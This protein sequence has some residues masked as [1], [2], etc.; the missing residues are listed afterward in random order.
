MNDKVEHELL[1]ALRWRYAVKKFDSH[2]RIPDDTWEII[3]QSLVLTP[4]SYGLQPWRFVVVVDDEV[5]ANLKAVSWNQPQPAE[6]SHLVV[7]AARRNV[8]ADYVDQHM[9][10]LCRTRELPSGAMEGYRRVLV[11]TVE[12]LTPEQ[13]LNWNSRQVYIALGQLMLTAS[14]LGV[15]A[16]PMEG[17]DTSQYDSIL[18]LAQTDYA[19]VVACALGYR[20]ADDKQA[21]AAKV[22]FGK[23]ALIH[24][25]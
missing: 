8:T 12:K 6:C 17:I 2:R 11:G 10:N 24:R 7:M 23:H 18:G 1:D 13:Q 25:I 3:E 21:E 9:D 14:L 15:D 20:H 4:S 16:C 19:T 5:K 22:R